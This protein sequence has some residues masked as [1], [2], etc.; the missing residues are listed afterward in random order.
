MTVAK[1]LGNGMPIAACLARE[2]V[3]ALM[4]PGSHG[5][6]LGGNPLAC[7]TA[8]KVLEIMERD[9]LRQQSADRGFRHINRLRGNLDG[10]PPVADIRDRGMMMRVLLE[11]DC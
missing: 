11:R 2:E 10:L 8:L 1:A 7:A 5:T 6:I 3:A 4:K 9:D